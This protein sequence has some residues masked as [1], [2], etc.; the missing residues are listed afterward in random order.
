MFPMCCGYANVNERSQIFDKLRII[1]MSA[2]LEAK[3]FSSYFD[4]AP[5]FIVKGPN[6]SLLRFSMLN[7]IQKTLTM[8]SMR[9]YASRTSTKRSHLAIIS[10]YFLL[11]E[12]KLNAPP[13]NFLKAFEPPPAGHRKVVLATNIAETSLTIPGI[14]VVIDCG[15][16]KTRYFTASDRTDVLRVHDVSKAQAIQRAGRAGREAPGKCYRLYPFEHFEKLQPC[17]VPEVLRSNLSTV[18]LEML[19]LGLRRPRKLKLIQQPDQESLLAAEQELI[20]LG[21]VTMEG[22]NM[23]LTHVGN[24][25]CKFPLSP[26]QAR[27]L[28]VANELSC[29]EEALTV[30]A[31]MSC[32]TVFDQSSQGEAEDI[33]RIRSRFSV[34]ASDH[35]SVLNVIQAFRR[36]QKKNIHIVKEWC[37]NNYLNFKTILMVLKVRKQLR[38]IAQECG[39]R[40]VSCGAQQEKLRQALAC[41]LF[42]N[43]CEY[44]RQ[45]DRYRLLVR[46][47][48]T[49][50]IHPSS[51]LSRSCP[52]H[53]VFTDLV[54]TTDL[55][56]RD[57]SII[58]Y[59]WVQPVIEEYKSNVKIVASS[60]HR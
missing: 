39:M 48:T 28:M 19:A 17:S 60:N 43:V 41:G 35:L 4:N 21:A 22:K 42:I 3:L 12:K 11:E 34:S 52:R 14:R 33:E 30:I 55:Y 36:E 6:V 27:V 1:I 59:E 9:S 26:D 18:L 56:A 25:L 47:S 31:A 57:V 44:D 45:E 49:L 54:R 58:H 2:T 10:W 50:K 15:K 32:E 46:P 29:L 37:Q 40:I 8:S 7:S 53:I 51:G 24:T 13:R 16:V 38:E 23:I 20:A 5:V